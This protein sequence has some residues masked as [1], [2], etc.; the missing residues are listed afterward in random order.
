MSKS[1]HIATL[2]F[3]QLE[4]KGKFIPVEYRLED[5]PN[6]TVLPD[7]EGTFTGLVQLLDKTNETFG[8]E[9]IFKAAFRNPEVEWGVRSFAWTEGTAGLGEEARYLGASYWTGNGEWLCFYS[10]YEDRLRTDRGTDQPDVSLFYKDADG[11]TNRLCFRS[12]HNAAT[13]FF[14]KSRCAGSRVFHMPA[15]QSAR[16]LVKSGEDSGNTLLVKGVKTMRGEEVSKAMEDIETRIR[17]NPSLKQLKSKFPM[18]K[19][20]SDWLTGDG[21]TVHRSLMAD[22]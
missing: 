6:K 13:S 7:E 3:K 15:D 19:S 5:Y 9:T 20:W 1:D 4:K 14:G 10:T 22:K 8:S 16:V 17:N 11:R 12:A 18:E 21:A 2:H